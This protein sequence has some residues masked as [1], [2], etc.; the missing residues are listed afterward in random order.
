VKTVSGTLGDLL[1]ALNEV[2][3]AETSGVLYLR[4]DGNHAAQICLRQGGIVG[5]RFGPCRGRR[6]LEL[7]KLAGAFSWRFDDTALACEALLDR[8]L[9]PP[10]AVF[11]ELRQG[12]A[13]A[14]IDLEAAR[15][16]LMPELIRHLGPIA[17]LLFDKAL[18][19]CGGVRHARDWDRLIALLA[20]EIGVADEVTEFEV[21][22]RRIGARFEIT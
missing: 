2:A 14:A 20:A 15:S 6:A 8:D 1:G 18:D 5:L 17:D 3:R 4:V 21:S 12:A 7:F 13:P 19:Q 9:G 10:A 11:E 16:A 22:A